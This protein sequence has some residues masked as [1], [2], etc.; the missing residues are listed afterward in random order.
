MIVGLLYNEVW[1]IRRNYR[2]LGLMRVWVNLIV[3]SS[4]FFL[5]D[6]FMKIDDEVDMLMKEED[7]EM[8]KIVAIDGI[9]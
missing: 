9:L 2:I 4:F 8:G 6:F 5:L 1:L 7:E 3:F